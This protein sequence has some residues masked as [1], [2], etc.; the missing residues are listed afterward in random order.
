[1]NASN[2][3][4]TKRPFIHSDAKLIHSHRRWENKKRQKG[5][6]MASKSFY[7]V[8]C[9]LLVVTFHIMNVEVQ[10]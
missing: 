8:F 1:M 5:E 10:S 4:T 9:C 2:K 3:I 7:Y 6:Q